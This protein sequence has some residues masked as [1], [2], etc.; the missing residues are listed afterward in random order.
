M[1]IK[2]TMTD[3]YNGINT[4]GEGDTGI[5]SGSGIGI[6]VNGLRLQHGNVS[7]ASRVSHQSPP[8]LSIT[9][10]QTL[11]TIAENTNNRGAKQY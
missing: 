1:V 5:G 9:H 7:N 8:G 4:I 2:D 10:T 6:T 3:G 11:A